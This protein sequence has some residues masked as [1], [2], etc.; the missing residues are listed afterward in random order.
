MVV[1]GAMIIYKFRP[2][3]KSKGEKETETEQTCPDDE[4]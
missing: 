4:C 2:P 3:K 1:A